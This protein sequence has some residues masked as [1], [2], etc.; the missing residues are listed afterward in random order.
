METVPFED[1]FPIENMN[2][3][4]YVSLPE[5]ISLYTGTPVGKMV[6]VTVQKNFPGLVGPV[7]GQK[8]SFLKTLQ[9]DFQL[10]TKTPI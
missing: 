8:K 10:E 7:L 1:V 4:C 3:Q 6:F 5:G 2:I 9:E